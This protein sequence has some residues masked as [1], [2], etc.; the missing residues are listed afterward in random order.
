ML[1]INNCFCCFQSLQ[2]FIIENVKYRMWFIEL[3]LLT[4]TI[5]LIIVKN[6]YYYF[7]FFF[8]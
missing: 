6:A 4:F 8:N 3:K 7:S 5:E 1:Q 2:E